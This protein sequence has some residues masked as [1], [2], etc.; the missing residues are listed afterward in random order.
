MAQAPAALT[1]SP[2]EGALAMLAFGMG[3][4]PAMFA[5]SMG[6]Q[7]VPA[8]LRM[9]LVRAVPLVVMTLGLLLILRGLGLD[10]EFLSPAAADGQVQACCPEGGVE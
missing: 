2:V 10:I 3:T 4:V 8:E 7:W 1:H 5:M 6:G 9:K